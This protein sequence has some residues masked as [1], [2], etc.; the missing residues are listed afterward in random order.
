MARHGSALRWAVQ[1]YRAMS[2]HDPSQ[3]NC[4]DMSKRTKHCHR[5]ISFVMW[6]S[7]FASA[8]SVAV[9]NLWNGSYMS[10]TTHHFFCNSFMK[11]S[12]YTQGAS[13]AQSSRS[14]QLGW[15]ERG[16]SSLTVCGS[17]AFWK[18]GKGK[19]ASV[20]NR[21]NVPWLFLKEGGFDLRFSDVLV[22]KYSLVMI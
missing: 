12:T 8:D 7:M 9:A 22:N 15:R 1:T 5:C 19:H 14:H 11:R 18:N 20:I 6:F 16:G 10:L 3:Q 17:N 2:R 13:C 21:N 4:T